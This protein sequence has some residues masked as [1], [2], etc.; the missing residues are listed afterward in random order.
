MKVA[1]QKVFR[2][3]A[4]R[5]QH[6]TICRLLTEH[7]GKPKCTSTEEGVMI[8]LPLPDGVSKRTVDRAIHAAGIPGASSRRKK[9]P[10]T[11]ATRGDLLYGYNKACYRKAREG[12]FFQWHDP[13]RG[14]VAVVRVGEQSF[15]CDCC[16]SYT[17][18]FYRDGWEC[19]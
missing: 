7:F 9:Y 6:S 19:K 17:T 4:K 12:G 5:G 1:T 10:V 15:G 3:H 2:F 18:L 8:T 11:R 16:G 13:E 14:F